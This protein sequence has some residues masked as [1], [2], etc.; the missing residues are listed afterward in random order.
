MKKLLIFDFDGVIED[1]FELT[2][3]LFKDY[4]RGMTRDEYRGWFDGNFHQALGAKGMSTLGRYVFYEKYARA[5]RGKNTDAAL[6]TMLNALHAKF[7]FAI[8]SSGHAALLREYLRQNGIAHLF[9]HVWG[10]E[11][12]T[13][14][15]MKLTELCRYAVPKG[16]CWFV[17]DTLGDIREAHA[18]N[19][20]TIAVTWG[21]HP[22]RRLEEGN[23]TLVVET[24]KELSDF[25]NA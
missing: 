3:C 10:M 1:T 25:L 23:P 9:K 7:V 22:R 13:N 19:M 6:R 12:H 4:F 18:A 2:F 21:F 15:A 24:P 20:P 14:K 5:L 16:N 17:T 8:V 11:K